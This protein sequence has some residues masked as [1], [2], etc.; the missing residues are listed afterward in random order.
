M[1]QPSLPEVLLETAVTVPMKIRHVDDSNDSMN[2]FRA[3]Q[4]TIC[5]C[6]YTFPCIGYYFMH[7]G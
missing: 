2:A 3:M 4:N 5:N 1:Q 6:S 7:M